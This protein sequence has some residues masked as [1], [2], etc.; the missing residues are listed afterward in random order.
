M[1]SSVS[2][3]ELTVVVRKPWSLNSSVIIPALSTK[4][5]P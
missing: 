1:A 5:N 2:L 4:G 3:M